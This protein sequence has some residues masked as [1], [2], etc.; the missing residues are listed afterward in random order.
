[1]DEAVERRAAALVDARLEQ[2]RAQLE[3][4]FAERLDSYRAAAER[5][6]AERLASERSVELDS[7]RAQLVCS[8]QHFLH[9]YPEFSVSIIV[10]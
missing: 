10:D 5:Q 9:F 6:A 8:S 1:M 7:L 4:E 2:Q 3:A